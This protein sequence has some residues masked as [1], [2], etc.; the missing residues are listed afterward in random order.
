M[1]SEHQ[2]AMSSPKPFK[3]EVPEEKLQWI[4]DRVRSASLPPSKDLPDEELWKSWGLPPTCAEKLHKHWTTKYDWR[5]VEAQIN[6][7]LTQYTIPIHHNDE[8]I[9]IHFVH[10]RSDRDDAIPLLF[11]HGWPGSFLEVRRIIRLLTH[12]ESPADQ[13]YHVVA[14]SL[15]GFAFS[16]YPK[17]PCSPMDMADI[18]LKLMQALGYDRFMAQGGDWGSI[19]S[20]L[21]AARHPESC[22][23]LHLNAVVSGPPSPL[24]HPLAIGRLLLAYLSGGRNLTAFEKKGLERM[25]WWMDDE[26]AYQ[27]IHGTKPLTLGYALGD[28][29]FGL[30]CW[31]REKVHYLVDDDFEWDEELAITSA[32]VRPLVYLWKRR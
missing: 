12:P 10:N 4:T 25:K 1:S 8:D 7:E 13:A 31:V 15:P 16:S 14:P 26:S 30:A 24:R 5:R 3:I 20:R 23:A 32:M 17:N 29:P 2:S 22:R 6:S 19:I 9:N 28:S 11:V 21:L 27:H 18:S